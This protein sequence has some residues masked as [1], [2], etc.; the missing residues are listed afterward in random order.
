VG[1]LGGI[2]RESIWDTSLMMLEA[3][4]LSAEKLRRHMKPQERWRGGIALR[5]RSSI[6]PDEFMRLAGQRADILVTHEGLGGAMHG[7]P[8]LDTLARAMGVSLVVHGHLHRHIDYRRE[9]WLDSNATYA[10][11]GIDKDSHLCW[12]AEPDAAPSIHFPQ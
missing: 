10:A 3:E 4:F 7:Q 5:H 6:F 2:F 11:F 12:P 9:G 8:I 1:G